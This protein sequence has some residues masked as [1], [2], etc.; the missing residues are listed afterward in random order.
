[1]KIL[2]AADSFKESLSSGQINELL[3]LELSPDHEVDVLTVSDGG[4]GFVEAVRMLVPGQEIRISGVSPL[5]QPVECTYLLTDNNKAYLESATCL[6]LALVREN[7]RN[8]MFTSSFGLGLMIQDA[9]SRG[10]KEV[11]IGLGGSS[12]NDGGTGML[13]ALGAAFFDQDGRLITRQGG[14]ILSEIAR[15]DARKLFSHYSQVRFHALTDVDN[16]LTGNRGAT[17]IY[18]PQKGASVEMVNQLEAGMLAFARIAEE[19]VR[20]DCSDLPGAGAAG[21]LGFAL[22]AFLHADTGSGI[23]TVIRLAQLESRVKDYDLIITGEGKLDEQTRSGKVPAALLDIGQKNGVPVIGICGI[24]EAGDFPGFERVFA[25]VPRHG[26]LKQ[27]LRDPV[28]Y[29]RKM[30]Q[31]ELITWLTAE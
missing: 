31:N 23:E 27:S 8:P 29:L 4:E 22:M 2:A 17:W 5:Q 24:N 25:V 7:H 19:H 10:A 6:G 14:Q 26:D 30:I 11:F 3:R 21:G 9:V 13:M 15:I 1:M 20:K 12:T 28:P 16:P 18:G